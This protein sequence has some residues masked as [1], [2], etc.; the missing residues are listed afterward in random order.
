VCVASSYNL[1]LVVL[2]IGLLVVYCPVFVQGCPVYAKF[3]AL[4]VRLPFFL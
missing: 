2:L 1:L 4:D 3:C